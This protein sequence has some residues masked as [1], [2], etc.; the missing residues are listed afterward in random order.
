[1]SRSPAGDYERAG[2]DLDD[3]LN[4]CPSCQTGI[5]CADGDQAAEAEFRAWRR[6]QH[7]NPATDGAQQRGHR[8]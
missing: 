7:D 5:A 2:A 4:T 6:W 1:M 3:H 8:A